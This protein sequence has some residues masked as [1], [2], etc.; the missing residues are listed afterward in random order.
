M[1]SFDAATGGRRFRAAIVLGSGLS[2]LATELASE[3]RASFG[4]VDGLAPAQVAGHEGAIYWGDVEGVAAVVFAGRIHL[5]E[6]H[7]IARVVEPIDLAARA[8]CETI[9]VTNAAGAVNPAIELGAPCLISDHI[10]LTGANPQR[11]RHDERGPRFLDLSRAYDADLRRLAREVDP[12]LQEGVYAG[13]AGPTYETPAEIRMLATMGADLVGMSTVLETIQARYLGM[14]VLGISIV[15]NAAA[16]LSR[17][18]L[19]HSE[20]AAAGKASAARLEILLRGF[21]A[22]LANL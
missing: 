4:D 3:G 20:V 8:G 7:D 9:V 17:Q 1:T 11:G 14:R 2:D 22:R 13:V 19:D 12:D 10:N 15:T 18:P 21:L 16:G 6:G 5:Y